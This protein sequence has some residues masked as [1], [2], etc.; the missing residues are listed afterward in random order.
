MKNQ[1]IVHVKME[2]LSDMHRAFGL[3]APAHP[4]ISFINAA[5]NRVILSNLP[6]AHVLHFYK[7]SY[8]PGL[9]G[10]LKYGQDYYDFDEGG[11]L[12]AAPN[13]VIGNH[14][15]NDAEA[16]SEYTLLIHPDFLWNYPLAKKIKQYGFFSY[17]ANEAL[18]LSEKEKTTIISIFK[19][20]EEELNSRIDDFSQDVIIS[21]IELLLNYANRF[22]KRQFITRKV[23]SNGLLQ[24]LE[25]IFD[26]YFTSDKSSSLGIPTVQYLSE[27]LN[28]S[29][30]YLSDMLRSLTGQNAQHL[31]HRKIIEQAKEKLSA[32]RLS[33]SEVAYQ[34]GFEHPQSFNKL[35]KAKTKTSPLEFR[36]SF[37]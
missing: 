13:Q 18:H 35:F 5:T 26:E 6:H 23:V 21:Q 31:I 28:I 15:T 11:L 12:F 17:S 33:V 16:C 34:L 36:K 2:S 22:Y 29:P 24:K 1:E 3:P 10:K 30:S 14:G 4:L 8:K 20:I 25:D 19:I 37:N 32:T 7:I 27:K 9:S